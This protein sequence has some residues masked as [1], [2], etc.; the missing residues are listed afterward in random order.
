MGWP[1]ATYKILASPL[2]VFAVLFGAS[3][4]L[5]ALAK[6]LNR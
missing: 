4:V 2:G 5:R 6:I 1:E 3:L